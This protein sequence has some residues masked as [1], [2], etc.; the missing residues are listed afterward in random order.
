M[1]TPEQRLERVIGVMR[2]AAENQAE[3]DFLPD[4]GGNGLIT[5][6]E[7]GFNSLLRKIRDSESVVNVAISNL[8]TANVRLMQWNDALQKI[9]YADSVLY[10]GG[11][12]QNFFHQVVRDAMEMS[13]ARYGALGIFDREG[14]LV[15]FITEGMNDETIARI[16]HPPTG[17][18]LLEFVYRQTE[19]IRVDDIP[20][21]PGKCGFPEGHPPLK[22]LIGVP[23]RL[24]EMVKGVLYLAD[25][26]SSDT[27]LGQGERNSAICFDNED[28]VSLKLFS[29]YMVRALERMELMSLLQES[30][31]LLQ[32]EKT[33][34]QSLIAKLHEAQNQLL[35]S[36]KMASIGQLAAGVAHEINNP[37]GYVN[38][39]LG[40]L[41]KYIRDMIAMLE[42]YEQ[43]EPLL[44]ADAATAG[45]I[46]ALRE[47]LDIEFLKEDVAALMKESGEGILRV[48]KIVQD[49][50][51]FSHVDEAEW[52]WADLHKGLD[53][54]LNVVWNELKYKAEVVKEYGSLPEVECL[55][56]QLNQVFMNLLVN[57]AHAIEERGNIT[58]RTGAGDQEVWVEITDN[59][60]GI[61]AENLKRIFDPFFT[62]KPVGKGTGLGLSLA[63][64]IVQKHHGRIEASSEEGKGTTFH[65]ALP[66]KQPIG[67]AE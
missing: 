8:A 58:I 15:Q 42:A 25:K 59:G 11:D 27:L 54:T 34:Q 31:A 6:L 56:S 57:A 30:N 18:G 9:N 46:K 10:H 62:T 17:R 64:S 7:N 1:D 47:K 32:Q 39:N 36:E 41:D 48:K 43:A 40:T 49:L 19:P 14:K 26:Q 12:I 55:P 22:T 3:A 60:K 67:Q 16:G 38:S 29:D 5:R 23:L 51:D 37:I 4:T 65:V 13:R 53:S 52:Q 2:V 21:H 24:G 61:P 50:K 66:V 45:R 28:E 44:A 63:Y 35:Q 33:E 20:V